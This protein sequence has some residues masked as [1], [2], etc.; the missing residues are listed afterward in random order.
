MLEA[1]IHCPL[2]G[3]GT[4]RALIWPWGDASDRYIEQ[5]GSYFASLILLYTAFSGTEIRS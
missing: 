2:V 4:I 1:G 3:C 5:A